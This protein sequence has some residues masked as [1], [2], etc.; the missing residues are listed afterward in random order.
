MTRPLIA[1]LTDFGQRDGFAGVMKGVIYT[2]IQ[3]AKNASSIDIVDIS[4]DIE[5][6]NIQEASWVLENSYLHFPP[7]SIFVCVV[8]PKVGDSEQAHL[9]AHWEERNQFFIA[10]DNGL[11]SPI[12]QKAK[13]PFRVYRIENKALFLDADNISQTFHGRDIYA[14]VAAHLANAINKNNL[15]AFLKQIG[16]QTGDFVQ[17]KA[18][19]A[20]RRYTEEGSLI[21]GLIEHI[22]A[23]G[24]LITNIPNDWLDYGHIV[25]IQVIH[26]QWQSQKLASYVQGE[27]ENQ[28]FLI[29]GSGGC[30]ELCLYGKSAKEALEAKI[31]DMV[32]IRLE[33]DQRSF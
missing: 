29:P 3:R 6:Q 27:G 16:H 7:N 9:L 32:A 17:V 8:D 20:S 13:F 25:D 26:H 11:L 28:V 1:L 33:K 12:A 10:P 22:D 18:S 14:P 19:E 21:D 31:K 23:F 30:L 24:N 15:E 4:H 2:V 5:A